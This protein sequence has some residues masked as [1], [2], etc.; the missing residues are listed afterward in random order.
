MTARAVVLLGPLVLAA[1]A[2]EQTACPTIGWPATLAV[3]LAD[4]WPS[5]TGRTVALSPA[6]D[7][8]PA[9]PPPEELVD[10]R[11]AFG[12]G[13]PRPGTV[14]VTV[15]DADGEV[16]AVHEASP[17]W[18]RVGGTEACGGPSEAEVVVPAP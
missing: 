4:T 11:A 3:Q 5:G 8:D 7:H 6:P 17:D 1:C 16:L 2:A 15:L 13:I 9:G 14:V 18:A 12:V 10:G